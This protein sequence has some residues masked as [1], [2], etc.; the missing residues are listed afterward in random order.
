MPVDGEASAIAS[1]PDPRTNHKTGGRQANERT[2]GRKEA[3]RDENSE[4]KG[5]EEEEKVPKANNK[6][7]FLSFPTATA[8]RGHRHTHAH[9]KNHPAKEVVVV[10]GGRAGG[11][12]KTS[13][14]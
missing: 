10:G 13:A 12:K 7:R 11:K 6:R 3:K 9:T 1:Q 14:R 2:K 4:Q 5:R 8:Q